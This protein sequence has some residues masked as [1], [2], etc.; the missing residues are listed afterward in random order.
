MKNQIDNRT[1]WSRCIRY[2]LEGNR[3][4]S[5][6][7]AN[8]QHLLASQQRSTKLFVVLL[9]VSFGVLLVYNV[10]VTVTNNSIVKEPSFEL[11]TQLATKYSRTLVCPCTQISIGYERFLRINYTLHR[12]CSSAFLTQQCL[13]YMR[14]SSSGRSLSD[15]DC[16]VWGSYFF[17]ALRS[18]YVLAQKVPSSLLTDFY[19]NQYVSIATTSSALFRSQTQAFLS[20]FISFIVDDFLSSLRI[21]RDITHGN[22]IFSPLAIW[23][24]LCYQFSM[25]CCRTYLQWHE[26]RSVIRSSRYVCW[27]SCGRST[28]SIHAR[29]LLQL[30]LRRPAHLLPSF[31]SVFQCHCPRC[32]DGGRVKLNDQLSRLL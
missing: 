27:L 1:F 7:P 31:D 2:L 17:Q 4:P 24:L 8:D 12:V 26:R 15:P 10:T 28:G 32:L 16:K 18:L 13:N 6:P 25:Y 29:V 3:F 5:I 30:N 11:Y 14:G 9:L 22:F 21:V 19:T 20:Q 23:V